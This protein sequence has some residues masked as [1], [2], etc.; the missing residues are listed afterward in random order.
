[1][2]ESEKDFPRRKKMN[3]DLPT[4][5]RVLAGDPEA[6]RLLV[7]RYQGPLLCLVGNL[8]P[9]KNDCD[10]IAQDAFL[11][12]Y[13]RLGSYDPTKG[14]F[15]TWLLTI[16]RNKCVNRHKKRK[17]VVMAELP[18]RLDCR[19]PDDDL[20]G[21]EFFARLDRALDELPFEQKT[22]FV[23]AEIQGLPHDEICR[24]EGV[25]LGTVKSRIGRAKVRLRT[26]LVHT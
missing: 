21:A 19:G 15:S 17:P 20:L 8:F 11:A 14:K 22:A 25:P 7:E 4:I 2:L 23:L 6:F 1:M 26:L 3:D 12:A 16:A 24:I 10:D 13:R 9:D 18:P 5:Q